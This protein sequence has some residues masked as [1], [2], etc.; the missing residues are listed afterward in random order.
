MSIHDVE[1]VK[2]NLSPHR[3]W[4]VEEEGL[5]FFLWV[6]YP[7]EWKVGYELVCKEIFT[8]DG[9]QS[10]ELRNIE[11]GVSGDRYSFSQVWTPINKTKYNFFKNLYC[12]SK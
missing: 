12:G 10:D 9:I 1:W 7:I 3:Y 4:R 8:T 11:F 5:E 6:K 2:S